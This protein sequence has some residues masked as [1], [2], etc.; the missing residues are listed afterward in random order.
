MSK[1]NIV[2]LGEYT[3]EDLL[4]E[5]KQRGVMLADGESSAYIDIVDMGAS[6]SGK[7]R[8]WYVI[9]KRNGPDDT[10]GIIKWSGG[11]RKYV[12][13]SGPAYYDH[14]CLAQIAQFLKQATD[15]HKHGI[16]TP[17]TARLE[18]YRNDQ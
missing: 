18:D 8:V 10:P 1:P 11:W 17:G 3:D 4:E 14:Y 9:N 6:E 16:V 15:D 2:G 13:H 5:L 7:T 12:Y